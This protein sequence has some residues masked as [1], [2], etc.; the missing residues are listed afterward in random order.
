[1]QRED[2]NP[3]EEAQGYKKLIDEVGH[4]QEKVAQALGKSRSHVANMVRLLN[5]PESVQ[6]DVR[7][8]KL[9]MGHA[10]AL[11]TS[12]SPEE[13]AREVIARGLSVRETEELVSGI[14]EDAQSQE[15]QVERSG[16]N[17]GAYSYVPQEESKP[18]KPKG[19][20]V[21]TQALEEDLSNAI[22]MKVRI[23]ARKGGKGSMK[24]EYKSL[25][26]LDELITKLKA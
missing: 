13:L 11:I 20:D 10:R 8:G 2:L 17:P 22:G 21:D 23:M 6:G 9:S 1:M 12:D 19:P 16:L 25:D 14:R 24:I 18:A 4:S 15:P 3:V 7:A 26:Q 5:L